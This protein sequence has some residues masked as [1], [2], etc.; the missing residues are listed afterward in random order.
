MYLKVDLGQLLLG[1][2]A[3]ETELVLTCLPEAS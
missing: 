1:Q 3:L 2:M